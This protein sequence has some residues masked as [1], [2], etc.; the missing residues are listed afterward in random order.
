[1]TVAYEG[2]VLKLAELVHSEC[3]KCSAAMDWRKT[4]VNKSVYVAECCGYRYT[5]VPTL[6]E[7]TNVE[8]VH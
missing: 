7:I 1:M 2:R 6:Y 4:D 3:P 5:A 8:A